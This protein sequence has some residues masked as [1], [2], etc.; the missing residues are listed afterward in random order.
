MRKF[1]TT[2]CE[3]FLRRIDAELKVRCSIVLIGDGAVA[4]KYEGK[5]T[6]TD[7]DLWSVRVHR[8]KEEAFWEAVDRA[9]AAAAEPVP[10][11]R[12]TI[13]EPPYSFEDRL[14]PVAVDGLRRLEVLVPEAHDLVLMKI[15][16]GEAHDLDAVEDIH[17]ASPLNVATLVERY[18]ETVPQV[19]GSKAMHRLNFLAAIARLFGDEKA[20]EVEALTSPKRGR[21]K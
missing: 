7:L 9:R 12:A 8:G 17:R 16:R 11:Q 14:L 4:L 21:S 6:T 3:D 20:A 1:T 10:I 2:Q 18:R 13:A 5:H 19:M 15:A